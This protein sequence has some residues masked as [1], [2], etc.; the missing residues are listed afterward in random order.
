MCSLPFSVDGGGGGEMIAREL[1]DPS[2]VCLF[3]LWATYD[4]QQYVQTIKKDFIT[5]GLRDTVDFLAN[6]I[7]AAAEERASRRDKDN[8]SKKGKFIKG[9]IKKIES[10]RK[11]LLE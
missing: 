2:P 8:N 3:F 10:E 6:M 9:C 11:T 4:L 5:L 7:S 1:Y